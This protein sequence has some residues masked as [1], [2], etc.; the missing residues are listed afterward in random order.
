MCKFLH[1]YTEIDLPLP[2]QSCFY[3]FSFHIYSIAYCRISALYSRCAWKEENGVTMAHAAPFC[4]PIA[5]NSSPVVSSNKV[6]QEAAPKTTFC[7]CAPHILFHPLP[8]A[9]LRMRSSLA[10]YD[11]DPCPSTCKDTLY[12]P[13]I[14]TVNFPKQKVTSWKVTL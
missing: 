13:G 2:S 3:Q 7:T 4:S 5:Y 9:G 10:L 11:A 6:A 1:G 14:L 12:T 8:L